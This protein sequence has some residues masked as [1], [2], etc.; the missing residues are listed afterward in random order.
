MFGGS[1]VIR[2]VTVNALMQDIKYNNVL[3]VP[4]GHTMVIEFQKR[5]LPH[6]HILII[7]SQ[8]HKPRTDDDYDRFVCAEIP[9][10]HTHPRL[11]SL[12]TS[13]MLHGPC[14]NANPS[15][16]CMNKETQTC[17]K[18]FPKEKCIFTTHEEDGFPSYRRRCLHFF[19]NVIQ[20]GFRFLIL[21]TRGL[22]LTI[23]I[24]STSTTHTSI[25]R[26]VTLSPQ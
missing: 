12:V 20:K 21:M 23:H 22:C 9:D 17:G 4:V 24:C 2:K 13:H 7:L 5:G 10:V 11:F 16:V 3:G 18:H 19:L 15:S 1:P 8:H 25:L 6:A 14:G 26:F